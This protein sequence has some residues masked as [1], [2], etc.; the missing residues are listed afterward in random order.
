VLPITASLQSLPL[1]GLL[2]HRSVAAQLAIQWGPT[3]FSPVAYKVARLVKPVG[4]VISFLP[5]E[6]FLRLNITLDDGWL[7]TAR[8]MA[9]LARWVVAPDL[10]MKL[11]WYAATVAS[12]VFWWVTALDELPFTWLWICLVQILE[13]WFLQRASMGLSRPVSRPIKLGE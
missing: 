11:S 12:H 2:V 4:D 7:T 8:V 13:Q 5:R 6:R 9:G 1:R 10:S 3:E